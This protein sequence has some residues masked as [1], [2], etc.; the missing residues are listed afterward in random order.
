MNKNYVLILR[1]KVEG[2]VEASETGSR[3][4]E[5]SSTEKEW[6]SIGKEDKII[7][8][9]ERKLKGEMEQQGYSISKMRV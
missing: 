7:H 6:S 9:L 4:Y 1:R 2:W 5:W 8:N 3:K